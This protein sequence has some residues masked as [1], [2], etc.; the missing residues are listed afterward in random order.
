[1]PESASSDEDEARDAGTPTRRRFLAAAAGTAVAAAASQGAS[2]QAETY[3]FGGEV[4]AWR[5]EAP[6]AIEGED[7]PTLELEA[8]TEYEVV[9]ENLD[10]APHNFTIQDANGAEIVSTD[11]FSEEGA[12]HRLTFTATDEM[13]QYICTIHPSTM[14]GDIE[15]AG[16]GQAG[17]GDSGP[18]PDVLLLATAI[19]AA[20]LSPLAFALFLFSRRDEERRGGPQTS[21]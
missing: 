21:D 8:G 18:S 13:A 1:M 5:G 4:Q 3:R 15:I 19:G 9:W 6:T 7:N 2:A 12:T 14:V 17:G 20:I 16:G 10:G 11:T